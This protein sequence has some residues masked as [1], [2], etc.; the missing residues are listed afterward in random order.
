MVNPRKTV[1]LLRELLNFLE[2]R[3]IKYIALAYLNHYYQRFVA[4]KA[5]KSLREDNVMVLV[6]EEIDEASRNSDLGGPPRHVESRGDENDTNRA[7]KSQYC[8]PNPLDLHDTLFNP[9]GAVIRTGVAL[10]CIVKL[11]GLT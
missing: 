9:D 8:F 11:Q 5:A 1:Y 2:G 6:R 10:A 7:A 3:R 4:A